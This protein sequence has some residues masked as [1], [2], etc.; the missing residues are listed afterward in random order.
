MTNSRQDAVCLWLV[1]VLPSSFVVHKY[2]GWEGTIVYSVGVAA[3]VALGRRVFTRLS[4][5]TLAWLVLLT[6][7]LVAVAFFVVYPIANT[8]AAGAGSD[9][10][11]ALNLGAMALLGGRFPYAQTTYLGNVL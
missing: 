8:H 3:S 6:A 9:D 11:D 2:L 10:D 5:R 4:T 1:L 7:V